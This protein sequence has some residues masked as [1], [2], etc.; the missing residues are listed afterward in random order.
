MTIQIMSSVSPTAPWPMVSCEDISKEL[1]RCQMAPEILDRKLS[2]AARYRIVCALFI[3]AVLGGP[4]NPAALQATSAAF[5]NCAGANPNDWE[6][7]TAA[8]RACLD[9]QD[10]VVLDPG[11]PGYVISDTLFVSRNGQLITSSMP[12]SAK[13]LAA[14]NFVNHRKMLR[15][16]E[17]PPRDYVIDLITFDGRVNNRHGLETCAPGSE[18]GNLHLDE[19]RDTSGEM[20]GRSASAGVRLHYLQ[21]Y[22]AWTVTTMVPALRRGLM[23]LRS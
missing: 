9:N 7:D 11:D 18:K 16:V 10:T 23:V 21:Q 14:D 20:R 1:W 5:S 12:W 6:D 2:G 4:P 13:I 19:Q 15:T 8:F 17:P 22:I 3:V